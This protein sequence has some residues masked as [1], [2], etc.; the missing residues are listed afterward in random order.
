MRKKS[1]YFIFYSVTFKKIVTWAGVI[2]EYISYALNLKAG[3]TQ[4]ILI[5]K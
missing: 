4:N 2:S 3:I 5:V 1:Q